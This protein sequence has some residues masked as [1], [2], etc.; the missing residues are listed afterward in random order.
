MGSGR[1]AA[2]AREPFMDHEMVEPACWRLAAVFI[3]LKGC[4]L[5][6]IDR[7]PSPLG[8]RYERPPA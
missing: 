2:G 4:A 1:A 6:R 7:A 8:I 5:F 3:Y